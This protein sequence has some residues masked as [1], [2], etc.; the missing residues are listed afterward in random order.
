MARVLLENEEF[1]VTYTITGKFK[2]TMRRGTYTRKANKVESMHFHNIIDCLTSVGVPR[3]PWNEIF[4]GAVSTFAT[5]L[6]GD[7]NAVYRDY[8]NTPP[9]EIV[10]RIV[11]RP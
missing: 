2:V 1:Y 7:G 11:R 3:E 5:S 9:H 10:Y 6:L 4:K 8:F